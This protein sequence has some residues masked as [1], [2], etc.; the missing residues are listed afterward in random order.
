[1]V[2]TAEDLPSFMRRAILKGLSTLISRSCD[3]TPVRFR[4]SDLASQGED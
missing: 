4:V 1:M 2:M 3:P